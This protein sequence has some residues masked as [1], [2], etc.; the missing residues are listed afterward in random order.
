MRVLSI[1]ALCLLLTSCE[2]DECSKSIFIPTGFASCDVAT[3]QEEKEVFIE[4]QT[5]CACLTSYIGTELSEGET[6]DVVKRK[7]D[8]LEAAK[9]VDSDS[10]RLQYLALYTAFDFYVDCS[11]F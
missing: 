6:V 5:V 2:K 1:F 4:G 3:C 8:A 10:L 11:R 7:A 9:L